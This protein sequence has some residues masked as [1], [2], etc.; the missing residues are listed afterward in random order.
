M[1]VIK[2]SSLVSKISGTVGGIVFSSDGRAS[3][4]PRRPSSRPAYKQNVVPG[5]SNQCQLSTRTI[6]AYLVAQWREILTTEQRNSW[7]FYAPK[8]SSGWNYFVQENG[9]WYSYGYPILL[10]PN[11]NETLKLPGIENLQFTGSEIIVYLTSYGEPYSSF[12]DI[13][14]KMSTGNSVT[15]NTDNDVIYEPYLA[16][17]WFAENAF[18]APSIYGTYPPGR[19]W[20]KF[21]LL[22]SP[23]IVSRLSDAFFIDVEP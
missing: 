19:T 23:Q 7:G 5:E 3:L 18:I 8:G 13:A 16:A 2:P 12:G 21:R 10:E 20:I 11:V 4:S 14:S 9:F 17:N 6:Y 15:R 1:A 22:R